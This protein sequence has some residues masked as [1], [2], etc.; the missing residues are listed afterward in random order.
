MGSGV[1]LRL[2]SRLQLLEPSI[3]PERIEQGIFGE[4]IDLPSH[5]HRILEMML[6]LLQENRIATSDGRLDHGR[7]ELS[8]VAGSVFQ[9]QIDVASGLLF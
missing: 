6:N 5:E 9:R 1:P 7:R 3:F 8:L 2:N 4:Q